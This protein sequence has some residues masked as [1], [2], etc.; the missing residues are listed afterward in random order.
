MISTRLPTRS[1]RCSKDNSS[2]ASR[3]R[4][5]VVD[6]VTHIGIGQIVYR[7][8]EL[9]VDIEPIHGIHA[10]EGV[11]Q[12]IAVAVR[13]AVDGRLPPLPMERPDKTKLYDPFEWG[14]VSYYTEV[15][16]YDG[17]GCPGLAFGEKVTP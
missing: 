12:S 1:R 11:I 15:T 14:S 6:I 2:V 3:S 17:N 9:I 5:A 4:I 8:V 16:V 7:V 13:I 10:F